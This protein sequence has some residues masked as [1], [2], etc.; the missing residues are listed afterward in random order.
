M[1]QK[2][3]E[4]YVK[5]I[6]YQRRDEAGVQAWL[7]SAAEVPAFGAAILPQTQTI[8]SVKSRLPWSGLVPSVVLR[9][10]P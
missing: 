8:F 9:L 2:P 3:G 4:D 10:A 6:T 1:V 7:N 5:L